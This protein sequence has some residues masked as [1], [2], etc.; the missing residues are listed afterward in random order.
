MLLS[1]IFLLIKPVTYILH[2]LSI[3]PL[4]QRN[5][6]IFWY[7][8]FAMVLSISITWL[9]VVRIVDLNWL[10]N[11]SQTIP[12][13]K[14]KNKGVWDSYLL[15][16][17]WEYA[18]APGLI[19]NCFHF[20]WLPKNSYKFSSQLPCW[21]INKFLQKDTYVIFCD[22][23]FLHRLLARHFLSSIGITT[24]NVTIKSLSS[25]PLSPPPTSSSP[26]IVLFYSCGRDK[27]SIKSNYR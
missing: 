19:I 14:H 25:L 23:L 10:D 8:Q 16:G 18:F 15:T 12:R 3:K 4:G 11:F 6:Y 26:L 2:N 13:S 5:I 9:D 20:H 17:F 22:L 7:L 21:G 1:M 27:I 24:W